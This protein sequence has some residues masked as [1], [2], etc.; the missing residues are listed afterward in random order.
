MRTRV[1]FILVMCLIGGAV[2][3]AG[4]L[5]GTDEDIAEV[6]ARIET[7][8]PQIAALKSAGKVGETSQGLLEAVKA[9][10]AKAAKL[11]AAQNADRE[12][13]F[14]LMAKKN[15]SSVGAVRK[16]FAIFRFKKA[17]GGD[18]FKGADGKW[19]TKDEWTKAGGAGL[20]E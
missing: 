11:I 1:G 17:G 8:S 7:R 3:A 18:Q 5:A 16:N 4:A 14:G 20:F 9:V 13:L 10:D 6:M 12:V 15:E 19:M 2:F